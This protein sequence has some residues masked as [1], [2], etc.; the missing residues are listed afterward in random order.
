MK[1]LVSTSSL[2]RRRFSNARCDA[3]TLRRCTDPAS[4]RAR[5]P[6]R[7]AACPV[8]RWNVEPARTR[9]SPEAWPYI[10][11]GL[12]AP[13]PQESSLAR[14]SPF[15]HCYSTLFSGTLCKEGNCKG[16]DQT[17]RNSGLSWS[18]MAGSQYDRD[19]FPRC[20]SVIY[21]QL[22][23]PGICRFVPCTFLLTRPPVHGSL[24]WLSQESGGKCGRHRK[25]K[26]TLQGEKGAEMEKRY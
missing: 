15:P 21:S 24:S 18:K 14:S 22:L 17:T 23:T 5:P 6:T 1:R 8:A 26:G 12:H 13:F 7:I 10:L 11:K 3:A 4:L 2:I 20:Y 19:K 16:S 25:A 9:R